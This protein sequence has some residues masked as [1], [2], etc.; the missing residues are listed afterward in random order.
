M[1]FKARGR[2]DYA[3]RNDP[4]PDLSNAHQCD[5]TDG[6]SKHNFMQLISLCNSPN[7]HHPAQSG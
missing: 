5:A 6:Q 4:A 7:K 2:L 1:H 3:Q